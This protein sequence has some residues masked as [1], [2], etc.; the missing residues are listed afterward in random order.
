MSDTCPTVRIKSAHASGYSVINES[1]FDPAKHEK[2]VELPP[3]P[4]AELPP[5]PPLPAD[6]LAALP[7]NWRDSM[8]F[9]DLRGLV[10]KVAG[11]TPEDRRQAVELI[12]AELRKRAG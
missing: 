8:K 1:D 12:E 7:K 5:P 6:P 11:R 10:E 2:F 3:P 9:A 4:Q